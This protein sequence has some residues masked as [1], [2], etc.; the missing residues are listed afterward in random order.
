M[1]DYNFVIFIAIIL[2]IN[3]LSFIVAFYLCSYVYDK[4]KTNLAERGYIFIKEKEKGN[5]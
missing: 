2:M 1:L 3:I 5:L 4:T